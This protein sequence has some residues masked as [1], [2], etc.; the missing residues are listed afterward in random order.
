MNVNLSILQT[1][2]KSWELDL[3][4]SPAPIKWWGQCPCIHH[5]FCTPISP[6]NI[7]VVPG[8]QRKQR[9]GPQTLLP[10]PVN[11]WN[12]SSS[13]SYWNIWT[14]SDTVGLLLGHSNLNLKG[15]FLFSLESLTLIILVKLRSWIM[16]LPILLLFPQTWRLP[17]LLFFLLLNKE[18]HCKNTPERSWFSFLW[19]C[20]LDSENRASTPWNGASDPG[21]YF[22]GTFGHKGWCFCYCPT[23]TGLHPGLQMLYLQSYRYRTEQIS[24]AEF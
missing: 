12:G 13:H 20:L 15:F 1:D 16:L 17:K 14:T 18:Q 4:A 22:S 6:W 10:L 21:S 3:R 9:T 24:S 7:P 11:P 23:V 5:G 19:C 8:Y 2:L